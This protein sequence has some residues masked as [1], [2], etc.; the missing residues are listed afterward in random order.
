[1]CYATKEGL[2]ARQKQIQEAGKRDHKKIGKKWNS[3]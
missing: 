2:K 1:M 3:T